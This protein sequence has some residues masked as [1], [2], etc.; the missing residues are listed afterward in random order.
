MLLA[1]EMDGSGLLPERHPHHCRAP[2]LP[3][4]IWIIETLEESISWI[5][6]FLSVNRDRAHPDDPQ[7]LQLQIGGGKPGGNI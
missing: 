4:L 3:Q 2:P 5:L 7:S 1:R 6:S